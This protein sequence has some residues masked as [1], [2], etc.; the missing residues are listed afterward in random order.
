MKFSDMPYERVT[1]EEIKKRY[2]AL[3][4]DLAHADSADACM[5]VLRRRY[6]LNADMTPMELCY[7]RHDMDVNDAFYAAEQEYYDEIGPKLSELSNQ[8]DSLLLSSPFRTELEKILGKQAFTI[9]EENLL[10]FDSR[11]IPL[12]Q[13]ENALLARYNQLTSNACA[14]WKGK[15]VK[16]SLMT[17][18]LQS[19]DRE[20]RRLSSL[21]V[22]AAWDAMRSELE[23]I[24]D[25]LVH[26][27]NEQAKALGFSSYVEL[28]YHL[29]R[30]IGYTPGDVSR[31]RDQVKRE[32]SP[33]RTALEENRRRRL[34]L[35]KLYSY[36][37]GIFFLEGNPRP[38]G[39][40]AAC[41]EATRQM[42]TSLSP[43]TAEYIAFLLDNGLYDAEIRDGKRGGG[44]MTFFEKYRSPFIFANFDGTSENAYIMCHEGGHAFQGYLKRNEELRERCWLTSEAAETH[45]MAMEFFTYPYMELFFGKRTPDYY[46]M[47]QEDA[48]RLI[49]SECLQ[50]EFQQR[51][52]EQP[53]MPPK[54]RNAL[55][56]RLEREYFPGKDDSGN[57]NLEQG[58]GWQRIPHMFHWPFYA[59]DYALAQVCALEY[60]EWMNRDHSAAWES[61]LQFCLDTGAKSFPQLV[62]DAALDDPFAEGTLHKLALWL[63]G[64]LLET[65]VQ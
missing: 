41:L 19:P 34:G 4:H 53:D 32:L 38:V 61:Y 2:E 7:V 51:V 46:T 48:I 44:Y 60:Y 1:Y 37:S 28:S 14:N 16:V 13:E 15:Q 29:M 12:M 25:Q 9:M 6:Q 39:D 5:E 20:T 63:K 40:T 17:P 59:I 30:R 57:E 27:R 33:L 8:F 24:Y 56:K 62:K 52:Y 22:S 31:F 26:N 55:W 36:D 10:G 43:Q 49:I 47:H 45:A 50:D 42:Y 65:S 11:L 3:S 58:C 64:R 35:E 54:E 23:E 21:A 18:Y